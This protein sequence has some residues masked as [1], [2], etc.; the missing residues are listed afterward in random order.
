MVAG[1]VRRIVCTGSVVP[2]LALIGEGGECGLDGVVVGNFVNDFVPEGGGA[3]AEFGE[4]GV[5]ENEVDA[6]FGNGA[7]L[8]PD[9]GRDGAELYLGLWLFGVDEIDEAEGEKLAHRDVA[10]VGVV[11][12]LL[13]PFFGALSGLGP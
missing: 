11:W 8:F 4:E 1:A 5:G 6:P 10:A 3:G 2:V 12:M 9:F 7:G 13:S